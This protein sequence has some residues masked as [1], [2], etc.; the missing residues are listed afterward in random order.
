NSGTIF[1]RPA[2]RRRSP[3]V[4]QAVSG[5]EQGGVVYSVPGAD[6]ILHKKLYTLWLEARSR[7]PQQTGSRRRSIF[8][9]SY[10]VSQT[11][12]HPLVYH[13]LLTTKIIY[14][15]LR[16]LRVSSITNEPSAS[17]RPFSVGPKCPYRRM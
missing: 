11:P 12:A 14:K 17:A 7:R 6:P 15:N 2:L 8:E 4:P 1:R 3:S 16:G 5:R 10:H 9:R 13:H